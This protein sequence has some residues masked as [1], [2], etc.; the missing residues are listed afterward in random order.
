MRAV[1][2][3][4]TFVELGGAEAYCF[5]VVELL[6]QR[7]DEVLVLHHGRPVDLDQVEKWAKLSFDRTKVCFRSMPF[8][9]VT[10]LTERYRPGS[11][12]QLKSALMCEQVRPIVADADLLV[13]TG[14]ECTLRARHIIECIHFPQLIFDRESLKYLGWQTDNN[15]KYA[16]KIAYI[17]LLRRLVRWNKN[18]ISSLVTVTNS[19]WTAEQFL[20]NYPE[21]DVHPIHFGIAVELKPDSAAWVDFERRANNFAIVGRIS[22]GKRT[23]DAVEIVSRLRGL[24]HDVGLHII[25]SGSGL[26][27]DA[28]LRAITDK[29]WVKWHQ[30]LNRTEMEEL[31]V[32]NKWGLHC[33]EHEHYGFAP[34]EMQ[35]LGCITFIHDSGGQREIILNAEQRYSDIDDAVRK[36]DTVMRD[37]S[38]HEALTALG[39]E[40][41]KLHSSE[42][43]RRKFLALVEEVMTEKR[44]DDDEK[45]PL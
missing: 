11:F 15:L 9:A 40:G 36:I 18:Y 37:T 12:S 21:A 2:V 16:A 33:C 27:A 24:G 7:F 28:L 23:L 38:R 43:F 3:H 10:R 31:I 19:S 14:L 26:Y 1:V 30:S 4:S 39:A 42:G 22:P 25:G 13:T 45:T 44:V 32:G 41:A 6:Q 35:A 8:G 34:G 29:P 20:R 17:L 5:R